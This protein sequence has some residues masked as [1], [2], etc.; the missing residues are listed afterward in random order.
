MVFHYPE[1]SLGGLYQACGRC[2]GDTVEYRDKHLYIN[3]VEQPQKADGEYNYVESGLNFVHTERRSRHWD[4]ASMLCW[5]TRTM[6]TC[7]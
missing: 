1:E 6:P 7:I 4:C 2:P 3:G 5:S